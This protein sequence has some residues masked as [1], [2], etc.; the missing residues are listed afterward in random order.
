ML[1]RF[2][3]P[4]ISRFAILLRPFL[5]FSQWSKTVNQLSPLEAGMRLLPYSLG[6][7]LASLPAAWFIGYWQRKG[8][9][10]SGP[11]LVICLGLLIATV[12]FG[13]CICLE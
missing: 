13:R 7:S 10:I 11:K 6:S 5:L 2:I 3:W 8:H 9:K 12:G 1:G 4:C